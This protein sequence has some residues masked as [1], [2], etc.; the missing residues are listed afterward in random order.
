MRP[1]TNNVITQGQHGAT[2]AVDYSARPDATVYAPEDMS[3]DSYARRGRG[4]A[5]NAL[6]MNGANGLHQF[7]HLER[8]LISPGQSVKKGQAIAIMGYTGYTIPAGPNGR[9]LHWWI[10]RSN[11]SY[12]YP[13]IVITE[14]FNAPATHRYAGLVGKI[15]ELNS[16]TGTWK[17][18]K[19]NSDIAAGTI[20]GRGLRYWV[21]DVSQRNNRVVIN[22]ASMGGLVDVPLADA[23]GNEY[24]REW[25]R[26]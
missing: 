11:G 3:W 18:Y 17:V 1:P 23:K 5:G 9:H 7:A 16:N 21:R 25:R 24:S 12:V 19:R 26:V 14:K 10:K 4:D 15:I 2:K 20:R 8:I 6:R 13:P 22:S